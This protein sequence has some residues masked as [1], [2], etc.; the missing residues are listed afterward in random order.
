[1]VSPVLN[2][3]ALVLLVIIIF[4]ESRCS[5]LQVQ[6]AISLLTQYKNHLS[7]KTIWIKEDISQILGLSGF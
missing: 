2:H 7:Q 1:M 6:E 4:I 5:T 3:L